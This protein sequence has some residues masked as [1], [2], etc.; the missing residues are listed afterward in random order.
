VIRTLNDCLQ[1]CGDHVAGAQRQADALINLYTLGYEVSTLEQ[2]GEDMPAKLLSHRRKLVST[3]TQ[4][5][6]HPSALHLSRAETL[7]EET[8]SYCVRTLTRSDLNS[9]CAHH[10][11][12]VMASSVVIRQRIRQ[13]AAFPTTTSQR[14]GQLTKVVNYA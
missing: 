1:L 14:I 3:V 2:G 9:S 11:A 5:L 10:I 7:A 6:K 8:C 12:S 13:Q 4:F